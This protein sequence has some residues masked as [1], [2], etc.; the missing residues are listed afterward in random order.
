M[1]KAGMGHVPNRGPAN[2][3]PST[4]CVEWPTLALW[5]ERQRQPPKKQIK[6]FVWY[7]IYGLR[8]GD[9]K[10]EPKVR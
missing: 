10:V 9:G 2:A 3:K 6:C 4:A 8:R 1:R 5:S 7:E